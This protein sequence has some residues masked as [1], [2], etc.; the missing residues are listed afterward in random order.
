ME[1]VRW[2]FKSKIYEL[3]RKKVLEFGSHNGNNLALFASYD[4]EVLGVEL[5]EKNVENAN[6]NFKEL[7]NYQK[8][9]FFTDDIKHFAQVKKDIKA[10]V[11][12]IPNVINF[13]SKEEFINLL[14]NSRKNKLYEYENDFAHFFIRARSIK[15]YRYGL[16][17]KLDNGSFLLDDEYAG[18]KGCICTAYQEYE[19]VELLEEHLNLYDFELITS[20]NINIKDKVFIKDS[21]IIV[22]GKIR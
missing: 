12:L 15:D 17:K 10:S 16:G 11:F 9:E 1:L 3:P 13:L 8:C 20:E 5:D 19:L 22:Y 6:Y 14:Q 2:F 7:E 4:F 18:E 21:D